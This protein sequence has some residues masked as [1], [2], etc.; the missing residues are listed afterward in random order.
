MGTPL[1]SEAL[2]LSQQ[3]YESRGVEIPRWPPILRTCDHPRPSVREL[4]DDRDLDRRL[5]SGRHKE[6]VGGGHGKLNYAPLPPPVKLFPDLESQQPLFRS[7]LER[8][9][10]LL[11]S[12]GGQRLANEAQV[13]RASA[14]PVSLKAINSTEQRPRLKNERLVVTK[15]SLT[16]DEILAFPSLENTV[17]NLGLTEEIVYE[18][19]AAGADMLKVALLGFQEHD[20]AAIA[21]YEDISKGGSCQC[22]G[23]AANEPFPVR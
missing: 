18:P 21:Q 5:L 7:S 22:R 1:F 3:S 13:N 16:R 14:D 9:A 2:D 20:L 17:L 11:R 4:L 19:F 8:D 12:Y 15:C 6:V 10:P 23:G